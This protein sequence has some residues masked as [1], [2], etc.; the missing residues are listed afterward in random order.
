MAESKAF[1]EMSV[2]ELKLQAAS[3]ERMANGSY[4]EYA[5][6]FDREIKRIEALIAEKEAAQKAAS[7]KEFFNEHF[8]II[9][10]S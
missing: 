8:K 1:A 6:E 3:F 4:W 9:V 10:V 5:N 2:E 7:E